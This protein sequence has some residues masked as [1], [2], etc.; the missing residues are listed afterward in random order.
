MPIALNTSLDRIWY[1]FDAYSVTR[2]TSKP[3]NLATT[4]NSKTPGCLLLFCTSSFFSL[5]WRS[6]ITTGTAKG[7]GRRIRRHW[8]ATLYGCQRYRQRRDK[9]AQRSAATTKPKWT[10]K[11]EPAQWAGWLTRH[12]ASPI[13]EA[14]LL[15]CAPH[16]LL[17]FFLFVQG[18]PVFLF[19]LTSLTD[20]HRDYCRKCVSWWPAISRRMRSAW[21]N[22]TWT[23]TQINY[24]KIRRTVDVNAKQLICFSSP[25]P[26][27]N[28]KLKRWRRRE[29][30]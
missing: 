22:A 11:S 8:H 1:R 24:L 12:S 23:K 2:F 3:T 19:L 14:A 5:S 7:G 13:S 15:F 27:L 20:F 21:L 29:I 25:P 16:L 10:N 9:S 18:L 6:A 26:S 28:V 30:K 17:F 4:V